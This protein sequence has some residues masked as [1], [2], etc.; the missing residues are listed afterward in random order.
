MK[1][2]SYNGVFLVTKYVNAVSNFILNFVFND[3]LN[4]VLNSILYS[5]VIENLATLLSQNFSNGSPKFDE[6]SISIVDTIFQQCFTLP[7]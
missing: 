7:R 1:A 6:N 4:Y 3:G 2:M 5:Y